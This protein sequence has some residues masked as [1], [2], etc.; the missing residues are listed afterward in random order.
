MVTEAKSE[1]PIAT[2]SCG[3]MICC[4]SSHV[5]AKVEDPAMEELVKGMRDLKLKFTKLDK[6]GRVQ[7]M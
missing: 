5:S 3:N 7:V 1:V 2:Y 6:K 4:K